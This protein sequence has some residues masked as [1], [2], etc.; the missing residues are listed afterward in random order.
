[1]MEKVDSMKRKIWRLNQG[2]MNNSMSLIKKI[3]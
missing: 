2:K 1:M 3:N